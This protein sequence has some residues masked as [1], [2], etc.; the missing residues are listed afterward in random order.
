MFLS[1]LF[2][3]LG[4]AFLVMTL[5]SIYHHSPDEKTKKTKY[6]ASIALG[7]LSLIAIVAVSAGGESTQ[8]GAV[9]I[10][11]LIMVALTIIALIVLVGEGIEQ[12]V[13]SRSG[14]RSTST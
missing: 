1:L 2:I 6:G 11:W 8:T 13:Q 12:I 9:I 14:R 7:V 3:V 10:G 5:L 4:V